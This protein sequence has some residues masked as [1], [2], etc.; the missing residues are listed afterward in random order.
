MQAKQYKTGFVVG[1]F[2]PLHLGHMY[3]IER[4]RAACE[5]VRVLSYSTPPLGQFAAEERRE[6]FNMLYGKS[7]SVFTHEHINS[8]PA[9]D[10]PDDVH[11]RFCAD[12]YS[13]MWDYAPPDAVFTSEHYGDGFAQYLSQALNH[14]VVHELVDLERTRVPVS[15]TAVRDS[16]Y[17]DR[18]AIAQFVD[19]IVLPS[20]VPRIAFVGGESSGK[21]TLSTA[22]HNALRSR[23]IGSQWVEEYGRTYGDINNQEYSVKALNTIARTQVNMERTAQLHGTIVLCD[24][25]PMVTEWYSE[26]WYNYVSAELEMLSERRYAHT[27][28]CD[29]TIPFVHD[30]SRIGEQFREEG[31]AWQLNKLIERNVEHTVISESALNARVDRVLSVL[32]AKGLINE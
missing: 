20:L 31:G 28:W 8:G 15:A 4:A 26:K 6:W 25:T 29:S 11:R 7:S 22:V 18:A 30:G 5:V 16:M 21:T 1:K 10:Q 24:T 9:N 14:P 23:G 17:G 12:W 27:F 32:S 13:E 19:P 2:S 3:L